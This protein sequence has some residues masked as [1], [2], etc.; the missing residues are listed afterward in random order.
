M[1]TIAGVR[2]VGGT[3][4]EQNRVAVEASGFFRLEYV[5]WPAVVRLDLGATFPSEQPRYLLVQ[6][7]ADALLLHQ[8]WPILPHLDLGL[9]L[10]LR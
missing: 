1:Q 2:L 4:E 3:S 7:R 8:P 5:I 9:G 6:P 10:V